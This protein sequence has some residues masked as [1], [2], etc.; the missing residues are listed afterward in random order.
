M[1]ALLMRAA[2]QEQLPQA[3][4]LDR[5]RQGGQEQEQPLLLVLN[6]TLLF[7][8]V[9]AFISITVIIT[10]SINITASC[11]YLSF[12]LLWVFLLSSWPL[13]MITI[14]ILIMIIDMTHISNK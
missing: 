10:V 13:H 6:I 8:I 3:D 2:L 14:V 12:L 9:L 11:E 5:S 1:Q 7:E 4:L